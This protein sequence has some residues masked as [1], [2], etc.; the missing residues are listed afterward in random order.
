MGKKEGDGR[1]DFICRWKRKLKFGLGLGRT[2]SQLLGCQIGKEPKPAGFACVFDSASPFPGNFDSYPESIAYTWLS[3]A[4]MPNCTPLNVWLCRDSLLD[5][6]LFLKHFLSS[7][8]TSNVSI[9]PAAAA[10]YSIDA[11]SPGRHDICSQQIWFSSFLPSLLM[12]FTQHSL[13]I[14]A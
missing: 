13:S 6:Y 11:D 8:K 2:I 4:R 12:R 14:V 7:P 10:A 9:K 5:F 3:L 1:G